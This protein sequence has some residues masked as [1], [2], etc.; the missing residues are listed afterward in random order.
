MSLLPS[1]QKIQMILKLYQKIQKDLL[2]FFLVIK[3]E[4]SDVFSQLTSLRDTEGLNHL[5]GSLTE[6]HE[7]FTSKLS[8]DDA[9]TL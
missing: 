5:R 1:Y 6:Y 7:F 8:S 4:I 3:N 2:Y 9:H